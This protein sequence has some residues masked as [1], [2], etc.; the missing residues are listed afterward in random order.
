MQEEAGSNN[1]SGKKM[2]KEATNPTME[3]KGEDRRIG[4]KRNVDCRQPSTLK[5]CRKNVK[6]S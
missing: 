1:E 4:Y 3:Q 6:F 2:N 5:D